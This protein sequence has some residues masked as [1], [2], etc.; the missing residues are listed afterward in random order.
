MAEARQRALKVAIAMLPFEQRE[1]F[2]LRA[3]TGLGVREI[4]R[5]TR[6]LP[7]TTKSR[8][9][10]ALRRT[11]ARRWHHGHEAA[12]ASSSCIAEPRQALPSA[13]H[14]C[15][16]YSARRAPQRRQCADA[17][18]CHSRR[19]RAGRGHGPGD[20]RA[21]ER[22]RRRARPNTP[23]PNYGIEEGQA[24]ALA[25][26]SPASTPMSPAPE[27]QEGLP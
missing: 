1:V 16:R 10:Y 9:R 4:A 7:E 2:L 8:L 17:V 3:E 6:S 26:E 5:I 14:G 12:A 19:R 15:V 18:R 24:H 25:H 22:A 11:C 23:A 20:L 21:L 27:A 13:A